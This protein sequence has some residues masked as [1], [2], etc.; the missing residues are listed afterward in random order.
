M[1]GYSE[2]GELPSLLHDSSLL[3]GSTQEYLWVTS[4]TAERIKA[5]IALGPLFVPPTHEALFLDAISAYRGND[6]RR[7]ILYAAISTEVA[8]G[9]V[10]DEE[11]ARILAT[12]KDERFRVVELP[13]AGGVT[14][15]KDPVYERLRRRSDF[16]VFLHELSLYVLRRSLLTENQSLYS[17]A[18]RLYSTRNQ[19]VHSGELAESDANRPYTLDKNGAMA[20]IRTTAALF[21]WLGLRS[22]FPLPSGGFVSHPSGAA[23]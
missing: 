19:L 17:D 16:S 3:P 4:I 2:I 6:H 10:I 8:F 23:W 22:D 18:T 15:R 20:A 21:A 12:Q 9:F 7:A 5:A 13:Q 11:Y 1:A 14:I